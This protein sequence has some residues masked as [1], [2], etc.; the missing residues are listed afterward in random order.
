MLLAAL[1]NKKS[2]FVIAVE[3]TVDI[4]FKKQYVPTNTLTCVS[5]MG[6][7]LVIGNGTTIDII[8]MESKSSNKK[9][10]TSFM[11]VRSV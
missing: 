4:I 1:A 6:S 5:W 10:D 9:L 8:S 7:N 3:P 11:A 2:V